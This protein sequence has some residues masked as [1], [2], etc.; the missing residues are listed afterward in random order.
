MIQ[1]DPIWLISI[2]QIGWNDQLVHDFEAV[3]LWL[4][5]GMMGM[6]IFSTWY[7]DWWVMSGYRTFLKGGLIYLRD[8]LDNWMYMYI[9]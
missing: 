3:S 2:F 8:S 7:S 9:F 4:F 5:E 6:G 1:F